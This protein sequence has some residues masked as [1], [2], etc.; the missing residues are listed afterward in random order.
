MAA[1]LPRGRASGAPKI[2]NSN[3]KNNNHNN[4]N[5]HPADSDPARPEQQQQQQQPPNNKNNSNNNNNS[6]P[7]PSEGLAA[8]PDLQKASKQQSRGTSR[9]RNQSASRPA[10]GGQQAGGASSR[11]QSQP[12]QPA[13][14]FMQPRR[15]PLA[16]LWVC[17]EC[18]ERFNRQDDL[19]DHQEAEGHWSPILDC[20]KTFV[21]KCELQGQSD[22]LSPTKTQSA[23][24]G[25][26]ERAPEPDSAPPECERF[27]LSP[28]KCES[29]NLSP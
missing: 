24:E 9:L 22:C 21:R 23:P 7:V 17:R 26:G 5:N 14:R 2:P 6:N 16:I 10:T 25:A 8:W 1:K 4:N 18:Q 20:G 19:M 3:N 29:F 27:N 13:T 28:P 11:C 12:R 15:D